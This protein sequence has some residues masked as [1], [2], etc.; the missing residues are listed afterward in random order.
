MCIIVNV[1]PFN[2]HVLLPVSVHGPNVCVHVRSSDNESRWVDLNFNCFR[3][4][5]DAIE[6]VNDR[7]SSLLLE[8][9]GTVTYSGDMITRNNDK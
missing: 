5:V 6:D 8:P 9:L 7:R 3:I 4:F 1:I 2:V